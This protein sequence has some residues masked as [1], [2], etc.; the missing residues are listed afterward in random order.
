MFEWFKLS[1]QIFW[2]MFLQVLGRESPL[3]NKAVAHLI[4]W[5]YRVVLLNFI[6]RMEIWLSNRKLGTSSIQRSSF[7]IFM[8]EVFCFKILCLMTAKYLLPRDKENRQHSRKEMFPFRNGRMWVWSWSASKT[9]C[10]SISQLKLIDGIFL[11]F[12]SLSLSLYK[13]MW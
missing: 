6:Y 12:L 1:V 10:H 13:Y 11:C 8:V 3:S 7:E 4:S 5:V 9:S 2:N